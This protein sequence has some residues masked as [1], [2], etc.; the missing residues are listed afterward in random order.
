MLRWAGL[1]EVRRALAAIYLA[2]VPRAARPSPRSGPAVAAILARGGGV[3][4]L[5]RAGM[6][7]EAIAL[8]DAP[9]LPPSYV[10]YADPAYPAGW[11][12]LPTPPMALWHDGESLPEGPWIGGVGSRVIEG[13]VAGWCRAVASQV[14]VLV[15]GGAEGCDSGFASS[16]PFMVTILPRGIEFGEGC[17]L[18]LL[19]PGAPFTRAAAMERNALIYA[20]A[21]VT[22]VGHARLREGG[23]WHGAVGALRRR[24]RLIV[25]DADE[26]GVRALISLGATPLRD[27]DDWPTALRRATG[28]GGLFAVP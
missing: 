17:V 26:P 14:P 3:S 16:A 28:P 10:T 27:P 1:E 9:E 23:T 21:E 25:R 15:T 2:G 22:A 18:S 8:E 12:R 19:P 24:D 20:A 13:E 6:A 4:A 7:A 5:R 11:R